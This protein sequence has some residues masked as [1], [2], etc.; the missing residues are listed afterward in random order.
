MTTWT[1]IRI[2]IA[3]AVLLALAALPAVADFEAGLSYYKSGKYLEAA[4][5]FQALVD[6]NPEYQWYMIR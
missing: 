3:A 4:G 2:I 6:E 5:E 1:S